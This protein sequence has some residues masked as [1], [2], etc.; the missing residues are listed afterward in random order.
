MYELFFKCFIRSSAGFPLQAGFSLLSRSVSSKRTLCSCGV[1][2]T[3]VVYTNSPVVRTIL[4]SAAN[5]ISISCS[6]VRTI[7]P[8]QELS[9]IYQDDPHLG[10]SQKRHGWKT[11]SKQRTIVRNS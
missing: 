6:Q 8:T 9:A 11:Q 10:H 5:S 4:P 2:I 3:F 7:P 1:Y